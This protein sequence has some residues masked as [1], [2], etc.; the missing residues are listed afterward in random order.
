MLKCAGIKEISIAYPLLTITRRN[1]ERII[2][3]SFGM[4]L[5]TIMFRNVCSTST[6]FGIVSTYFDMDQTLR[7]MRGYSTIP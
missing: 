7:N 1:L 3:N 5:L 2:Y 4:N 6:C